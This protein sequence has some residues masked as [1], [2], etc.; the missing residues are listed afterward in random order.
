M[1]EKTKALSPARREKNRY[2]AF[3]LICDSKVTANQ[4]E[5]TIT[6]KMQELFGIQTLAKAHVQLIKGK[7][8]E[9]AK[10]GI[11]KV[12]NKYLD[13][14]RATLACITHIQHTTCLCRSLQASGMI[15]KLTL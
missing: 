8:Q 3:E 13:Q 7:W 14:L 5:T 1:P 4:L 12:Q 10:K 9:S 2:L 15:N 11:L 6:S